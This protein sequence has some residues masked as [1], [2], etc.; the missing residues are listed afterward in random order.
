M[1]REAV[2]Q[3]FDPDVAFRPRPRGQDR[4][5]LELCEEGCGVPEE[6]AQGV[7]GIKSG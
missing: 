6:L 4:L 3:V 2:W 7:S 5:G 1:D